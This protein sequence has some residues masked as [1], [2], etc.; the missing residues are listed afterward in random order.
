MNNN[1]IHIEGSILS[2]DI[3]DKIGELKGQ[4]PADFA[5]QKHTVKDE[6]SRAWADAMD[7]WRIYQRRVENLSE[8]S[9][10]ITETRN[11]WIIPLLQLL[12]YNPI[13]S[14]FE[15]VMGK[16]FAISHRS[17]K[18]N[19]DEHG[20]ARTDTEE[21]GPARTDTNEQINDLFGD[22]PLHIMGCRNQ[23]DKKPKVGLR[24]SPHGLVQEYLNLTEHLY[25]IVTNGL[26]LRL[27]RNSSR[28]VKLSYLEFDLEQICIDVS[29]NSRNTNACDL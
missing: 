8:D 16:S 4:K 22:F 3:I 28:L 26:Q 2:S 19:T 23:L 15:E 5:I 10:G 12:G 27:L 6:I 17:R 29:F 18:K 14:N 21:H 11:Y 20:L 7:Y 1:C 24:M 13:K 9:H 25:G